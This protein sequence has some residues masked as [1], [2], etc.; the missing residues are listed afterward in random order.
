MTEE[1]LEKG[2]EKLSRKEFGEKY[3]NGN[4]EYYIGQFIT[5]EIEE[6][7]DEQEQLMI[8]NINAI[9]KICRSN[10][11]IAMKANSEIFELKRKLSNEKKKMEAVEIIKIAL[12][13]LVIYLIKM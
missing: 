6:G 12:L 3:W 10:T 5:Q 4:K 1:K 2:S 7:R 11:M 13:V 8:N 9:R